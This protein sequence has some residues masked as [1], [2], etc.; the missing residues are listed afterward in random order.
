VDAGFSPLDVWEIPWP[1]VEWIIEAL[2]GHP[3][4]RAMV[5]QFFECREGEW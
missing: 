1:E 4:L 5:S 3:P 2:N